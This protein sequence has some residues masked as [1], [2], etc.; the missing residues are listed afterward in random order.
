MSGQ[1]RQLAAIMFTDIV[2]YTALMGKDEQN[3]FELLNKNRQIQKPI[4]GQYNGRWIK[5]L[6][7]GVM[8]SFNTVSDAV[9][10][11]IKI[12]QTCNTAKDFQ[13]RIG[14][15]LGEVVFENDD[16]FG[17][18]VNIASRIQALAPPGG[19]WISESVYNNVS[20]KIDIDTEFVKT[21]HLKNVKD[22][23]RIYQVKVEG[24][25]A[26]EPVISISK[27]SESTDTRTL[28]N[29]RTALLAIGAVLI[30]ASGYFIYTRFQ[31]TINGKEVID[32]SIAVLPFTDMSPN[33]DHEYFG[34]GIAEAIINGLSQINDLKV[35]ARSSSFQFK[36]RNEDLGTI[37]EMLGVATALEGSIKKSGDKIRVTAT[38]TK[39]IDGTLLWSETFDRNLKDYLLIQDEITNMIVEALKVSFTGEL[40][41]SRHMS[42]KEEAIKEYQ[43]GRYFHDRNGQGDARIA[44]NYFSQAVKIDSGFALAWAYRATSAGYADS[45]F[46]NLRRFNQIAMDL[47]P[48]LAEAHVNLGQIHWYDLNFV[49][50]EKEFRIALS[51]GSN[52]PRVLRNAGRALSCLGLYQEGL[53]LC[54][55]A[56]YLDPLQSCHIYG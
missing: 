10:A 55:K 27:K 31:K 47:N 41:L 38:L 1:S 42:I 43:Q 2:G 9:N 22:P 44:L 45:T 20:N 29:K 5:E 16:V 7:D 17:D 15:H 51:L 4:I 33:H 26:P 13:L 6:G 48:N 19:I 30:L 28:G 21:E 37:G 8:A 25:E 14:I 56:V 12:Q 11:A 34:D 40:Q 35:I 18:G 24:L 53:E 23:V 46:T 54:K 49:Q 36:G 52:H 50:A 3:A 39:T 32:R